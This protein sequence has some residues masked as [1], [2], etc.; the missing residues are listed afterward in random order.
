MNMNV[1]ILNKILTNR[2]QEHMKTIIQNDQVGARPE[3]PYV[4]DVPLTET[5]R[6]R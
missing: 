3:K 4:R 5:Q 6:Q 1:K 2:I